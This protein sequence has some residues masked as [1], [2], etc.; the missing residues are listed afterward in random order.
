MLPQGVTAE[1]IAPGDGI[2][3]PK[4]GNTVRPKHLFKHTLN[5]PL[6]GYYL[7]SS[8][9]CRNLRSP[10]SVLPLQLALTEPH[11]VRPAQGDI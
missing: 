8:D 10:L 3:F 6:F 9:M 11:I 5:A 1:T 2:T 7:H 4:D